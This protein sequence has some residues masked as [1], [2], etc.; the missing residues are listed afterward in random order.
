MVGRAAQARPVTALAD[1][2]I[3]AGS[4]SAP[5]K[6][7][8]LRHVLVTAQQVLRSVVLKQMRGYSYEELAFHLSDSQSYRAF[9]RFELIGRELP[10]VVLLDV[11]L[12]GGGGHAVI[13]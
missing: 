10:D 13:T 6:L 3:R 12:P 9:C 2:G 4:C 8:A 5:V 1:A 11:H 7:G